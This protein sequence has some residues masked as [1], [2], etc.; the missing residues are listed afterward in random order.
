MTEDGRRTVLVIDDAPAD[1]AVLREELKTHYR[2]LAATD[3]LSALRILRSSPRPDLVLLDVMMPGMDGYQLCR[4]L[5]ADVATR[6]IP[7]IFVTAKDADENEAEGFEAG[8]VD[9]ITKPVNPHLV[10]S[11]VKAHVELKLAREDLERQNEVLR[12]NA[13]LRE[14]VEAMGRHDLKNPLMAVM[15]VPRLLQADTNLTDDQRRLLQIVVDA[16]HGMLEMINRSIDMYRMETGTYTLRPV[17][18]DVLEILARI[19]TGLATL[20]DE[21]NLTWSVSCSPAAPAQA[22]IRALGEDLLVYTMLANLVRNALEASPVRGKIA[23]VVEKGTTVVIA[24]HNAGAVPERVRPRFFEKHSTEGKTHG[25]GLGAYSA[26]LIACTLGG[27]IR[28]ET[29]E[30]AGTTV[31]VELPGA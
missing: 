16:A 24:I 27:S 30:E 4:D 21:K 13:R 20:V 28:F 29:S 10:R 9:Y 1:I 11:R 25:A 2:V 18:V 31:T 5:K 3:H 14:E 26:R 7:V 8:C 22:P 6:D 12:E 19:R 15:N 17:P 23:I